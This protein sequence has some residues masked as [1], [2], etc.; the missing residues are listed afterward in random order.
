MWGQTGKKKV[1]LENKKK[2]DLKLPEILVSIRNGCYFLEY[3]GGDNKLQQLVAHTHAWDIYF[4]KISKNMVVDKPL[5]LQ[6]R[7]SICSALVWSER[8]VLRSISDADLFLYAFIWKIGQFPR[9][10]PSLQ[11]CLSHS[12][13][14]PSI[15]VSTPM[16][17]LL[18]SLHLFVF[19]SPFHPF[20]SASY[21]NKSTRLFAC[22]PL[23]HQTGF[24]HSSWFPSKSILSSYIIR[25]VFSSK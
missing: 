7:E 10:S 5:M 18:C 13:S 19:S 11:V 22:F 24:T 4:K 3:W 12:L 6:S 14:N 9:E 21:T 8:F 2:C 16:S 20:L 1:Q 23:L 17:L 25:S 15:L